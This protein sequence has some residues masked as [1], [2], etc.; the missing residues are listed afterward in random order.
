MPTLLALSGR[1]RR[2]VLEME[3]PGT[4]QLMLLKRPSQ[5]LLKAV[6]ITLV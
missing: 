6:Q 1:Y 5:A 2:Q 3:V 4:I